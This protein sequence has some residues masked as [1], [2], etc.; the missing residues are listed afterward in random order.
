[1]TPKR[2]YLPAEAELKHELGQE[3]MKVQSQL[4]GKANDEL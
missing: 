4:K 3:R 2:Q 1:M